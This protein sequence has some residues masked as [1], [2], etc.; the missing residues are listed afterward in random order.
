MPQK[1]KR[2][3]G[4]T[5]ADQV[6]ERRTKRARGDKVQSEA[7]VVRDPQLLVTNSVPVVSGDKDQ[8]EANVVS[9]SQLPVADSVPLDK[10]A[11]IMLDKM[12]ARGLI[13]SQPSVAINSNQSPESSQNSG[14]QSES[15]AA[16]RC[17]ITAVASGSMVQHGGQP[18]TTPA[19]IE[20]S[21]EVE[22]RGLIIY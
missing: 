13:F 11:D 17:G 6:T 14:T 2:N 20:Q 18:V 21:G 1:R 12:V 19:A 5:L 16:T 10:L 4:R 22:V 3:V 7:S 8:S 9:N 15:S